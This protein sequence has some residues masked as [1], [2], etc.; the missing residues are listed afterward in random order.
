MLDNRFYS[1]LTKHG[2][3]PIKVRKDLYKSLTSHG[4]SNPSLAI[5]IIV[6][7][8]ILPLE[9]KKRRRGRNFLNVPFP[10]IKDRQEGLIIHKLVKVAIKSK[11]SLSFGERLAFYIIQTLR[12]TGPIVQDR[13]DILRALKHGRPFA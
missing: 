10:I 3:N 5:S 9:T 2:Q 7:A 1:L 8:I 12:G 11:G 6:E 13:Q 4:F